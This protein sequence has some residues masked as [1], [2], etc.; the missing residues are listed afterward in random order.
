MGRSA[1]RVRTVRKKR[2]TVDQRKAHKKKE[3]K[4]EKKN[5]K[6]GQNTKK[7]IKE[8]DGKK[9]KKMIVGE[10]IEECC[11]V[12]RALRTEQR[13]KKKAGPAGNGATF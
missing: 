1:S 9:K 6:R 5:I 11:T 2:G 3:R 10:I 4:A 8:E 7:E 13:W 12:A